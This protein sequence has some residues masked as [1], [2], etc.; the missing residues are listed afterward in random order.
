VSDTPAVQFLAIGL[1]DSLKEQV[2]AL[3]GSDVGVKLISTED[4]LEESLETLSDGI[5]GFV[6]A[7]TQMG[8]DMACEVGQ[9]MGTQCPQTPC[10]FI[11]DDKKEL[12]TS[13][14]K[15]NGFRD[16]Y[17]LPM[18]QQELEMA[19]GRALDPEALKKRM[20]K[21]VRIMDIEPNSELSF[22]TYIYM[23]LNK[24]Y[25]KY[26]KA[27]QEF[28]SD[29][30]EKLNAHKK[31]SI[32]LDQKEMDK[33]YEYT[34]E[35]LMDQAYGAGPAS[36]TERA[37]KLQE[38]IRGLFFDIFDHKSSSFEEGKSMTASCQ[39]I[40]SQF[41]TGGKTDNWYSQLIRSVGGRSGGYSHAANVS[42]IATLF[43]I[44]LGYENP[45]DLAI[46]GF[47]HDISLSDFPPDLLQ[48]GEEAWDEDQKRVYQ[49]HPQESLNLI[50]EKK[51]IL[52]QDAEAAILQHHERFDGKGFPHMTSGPRLTTAAQILSLADQFEY[53]TDMSE[54]K[55]SFGPEEAV[56]QI[57][58]T[59]SIDPAI[60]IKVRKLLT[61]SKEETMV[62]EEAQ[63]SGA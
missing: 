26:T 61:N 45:E 57:A 30:Y 16:I 47:L 34:A 21:S 27:D 7:G 52:S 11:T 37:E 40:V 58:K 51:M 10:F 32:F 42:T 20:Y 63:K 49:N 39:K 8:L 6:I 43:A 3:C 23:P 2:G 1:S 15:K 55:Q 22:D 46:A 48:Q 50:K 24:K 17:F 18:D 31:G 59:G 19:I 4:E 9:L 25:I 12:A 60:I 28:S 41:I 5:Y 44:G 33:F 38:S 54:G 62:S 36:E 35:K 14:L 29:K 13:N 53:L 56:E